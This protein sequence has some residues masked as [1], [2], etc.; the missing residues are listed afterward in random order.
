[1]EAW[2]AS[3]TI[4]NIGEVTV[5]IYEGRVCM[6]HFGSLKENEE[7]IKRWLKKHI[8]ASCGLRAE[9]HPLHNKVFRELEEY[10]ANERTDFTVPLDMRGTPFQKRVWEALQG[11]PYGMTKSYAE[12]AA[13]A[14]SPKAFRAVGMANN[15]NPVSIIVPCHRVIGKNGKMVG[16]GGGVHVKEGLLELERAQAVSR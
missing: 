9:L 14:D 6:L 1:M 12:I 3:R 2:A 11:I 7:R 4:G 10:E 16:F 8:G 13:E 5:V 15:K